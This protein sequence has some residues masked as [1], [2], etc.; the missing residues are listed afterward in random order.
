M[1][2]SIG[3]YKEFF[4]DLGSP[5]NKNLWSIFSKLSIGNFQKSSRK[6]SGNLWQSLEVVG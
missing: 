2:Q 5:S 1:T 3:A 4:E 6:S